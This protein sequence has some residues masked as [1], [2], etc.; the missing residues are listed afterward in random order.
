[1]ASLAYGTAAGSPGPFE[2]NTPAGCRA[3]TSAAVV[4]PGTTSTSNHDAR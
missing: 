2:R 4:E 3:R 1:M